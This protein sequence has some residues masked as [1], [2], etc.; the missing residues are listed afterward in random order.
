MT[1]IASSPITT[2]SLTIDEG[3]SEVSLQVRHLLTK[4]RGRFTDFFG[5]HSARRRSP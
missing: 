5:R 1:A 3:H 2:Q 4:V